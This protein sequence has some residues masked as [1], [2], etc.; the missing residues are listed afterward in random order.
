[1]YGNDIS[2]FS[3]LFTFILDDRVKISLVEEVVAT[4]KMTK[5]R[6]R[7]MSHQFQLAL[8]KRNVRQR[9]QTQQ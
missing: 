1:M 9:D 8:A 5:T 7:N 6:R 4:K 3:F 2:I